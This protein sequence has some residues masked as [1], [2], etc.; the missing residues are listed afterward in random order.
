MDWGRKKKELGEKGGANIL[1]CSAKKRKTYHEKIKK[2]GLGDKTSI[3]NNDTGKREATRKIARSL[4]KTL[5]CP[6]KRSKDQRHPI[7]APR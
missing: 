5:S 4:A 3:R 7:D 6:E 2:P 1:G